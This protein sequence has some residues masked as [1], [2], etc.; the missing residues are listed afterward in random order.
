MININFFRVFA[1]VVTKNRS[2]KEIVLVQWEQKNAAA[3]QRAIVPVGL[4][5]P[6][7]PNSPTPSMMYNT[8]GRYI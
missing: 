7:T 5:N 3:D 1:V 2:E 4:R 8:A 6:S